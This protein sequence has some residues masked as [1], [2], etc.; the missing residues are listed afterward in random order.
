MRLVKANCHTLPTFWLEISHYLSHYSSNQHL[1]CIPQ[2]STACEL[3][4]CIGLFCIVV[5][6]VLDNNGLR[7][8]RLILYFELW[9][10]SFIEEKA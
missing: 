3:R 5:T 8:D 4:Q 6:A 9:F 2:L 1:P 7:E 10:Q